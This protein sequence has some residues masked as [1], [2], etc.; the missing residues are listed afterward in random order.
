MKSILCA[1]CAATLVLLEALVQECRESDTGFG[2]LLIN[3]GYIGA[4][5]VFPQFAIDDAFEAGEL[6]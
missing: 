5:I 4:V 6:A 1:T 3:H 2:Q